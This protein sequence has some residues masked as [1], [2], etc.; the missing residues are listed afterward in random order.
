MFVWGGLAVLGC[1][2]CQ[3]SMIVS[4]S[5]CADAPSSAGKERWLFLFTSCLAARMLGSGL[6]FLHRSRPR[7]GFTGVQVDCSVM[8]HAKVLQDGKVFFAWRLLPSLSHCPLQVPQR[9]HVCLCG[10]RE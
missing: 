2:A 8:Q 4:V 9:H 10:M 1:L 7:I 6:S 5:T 3:G